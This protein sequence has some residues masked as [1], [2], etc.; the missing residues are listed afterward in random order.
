MEGRWRVDGGE[1]GV[2]RRGL[3]FG[4]GGGA[5]VETSSSVSFWWLILHGSG[6]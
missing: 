1:V 4:G 5:G 2:R 6:E 3:W